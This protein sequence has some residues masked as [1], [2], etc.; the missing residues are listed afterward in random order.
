M[1]GFLFNIFIK[2]FLNQ[3]IWSTLNSYCHRVFFLGS[4]FLGSFILRSLLIL[5]VLSVGVALLRGGLAEE[6][7][8]VA[9]LLPD[10]A[11]GVIVVS[12]NG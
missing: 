4:F 7:L 2:T 5:P 6:V 9:Y 1:Y 3:H 11:F 10:A 12:I 8:D